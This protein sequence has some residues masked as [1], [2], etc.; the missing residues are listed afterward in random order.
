MVTMI[1]MVEYEGNGLGGIMEL[2][3]NSNSND[4]NDLYIQSMT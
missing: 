1:H 3:L 4:L 2:I